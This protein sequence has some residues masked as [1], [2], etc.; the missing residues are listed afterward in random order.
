MLAKVMEQHGAV[1]FN[2]NGYAEEWH[3]E[4]EKRGLKNLRTTVDALPEYL[5]P[6]AKKPVLVLRRVQRDRVWSPA[7]RSAWSST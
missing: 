3:V 1:V 6:E 4:A 2:G 7:S 5:S